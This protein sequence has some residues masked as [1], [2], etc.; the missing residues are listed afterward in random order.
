VPIGSSWRQTPWDSRGDIFFFNWTLAVI[1]III[2]RQRKHIS[3]SYPRKRL[4]HSD[5]LFPR[6]HLHGKVFACSFFSIGLHVKL[7]WTSVYC[8]RY[9]WYIRHFGLWSYCR[10]QVIDCNF[11]DRVVITLN[12]AIND[13]V[14]D[15]TRNLL[16]MSVMRCL[17][18][19][20]AFWLNCFR[21]KNKF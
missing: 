9:V 21:N 12:L 1:E 8:L 4:S 11:T 16:N 6:I 13:E 7:C 19:H 20:W 18:D 5:G 10:L 17:L 3:I 14:G 2:D 15:R